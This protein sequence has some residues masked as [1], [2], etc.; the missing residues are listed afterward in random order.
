MLLDYVF[1]VNSHDY[2][3]VIACNT[4]RMHE[5]VLIT[6]VAHALL[7]DVTVHVTVPILSMF[8]AALGGL[9]V[10]GRVTLTTKTVRFSANG[11]N[12]IM[13]SGT[14]DVSV[15]L[16]QVTDAQVLPGSQN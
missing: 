9:W 14:L 8:R 10:G 12:R 15:P 3:F 7:E 6:K 11:V 16:E 5:E 2:Q 13:Q 4:D 1:V